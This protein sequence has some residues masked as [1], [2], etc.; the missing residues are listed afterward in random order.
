LKQFKDVFNDIANETEKELKDFVE[1]LKKAQPN[2]KPLLDYY[3]TELN[4]LKNEF[5]T[6]QTIKDIWAAL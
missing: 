6:D 1:H 4:K 2:M 3:E 5:N